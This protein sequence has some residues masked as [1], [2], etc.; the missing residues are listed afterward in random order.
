[1]KHLR[2]AAPIVAAISMLAVACANPKVDP[3]ATFTIEGKALTAA[4]QPLVSAEVR[5]VRYFHLNKLF[6]PSVD[7]LF[8]CT[9]DD[10]DVDGFDLELGLVKTLTTDMDGRFE[11][12][13]LGEDIIAKGGRR[14]SLGKSEVSNLVIIVLDPDDLDKDAGVFSYSQTFQQSDR[15]WGVGNLELWDSDARADVDMAATTGRIELS[16]NKIERPPSSPVSQRYRVEIRGQG[17]RLRLRCNE[18]VAGSSADETSFLGGCVSSGNRLKTQVSAHTVWTHYADNGRFT[19][20]VSGDG[21]DFRH[22][23]KMVV[24]AP[25]MDPGMN[26]D[27]VRIG[28]VWAVAGD[29][30]QD[31]ANSSATDGK[32]D[33]RV[34]IT[35]RATE[36]Y[37]KLPAGAVSDAGLLNS[38]VNDAHKACVTI[39]FQ[40]TDFNTLAEARGATQG[41]VQKGKFC[42]GGGADEEMSALVGFD[43]T[44]ANGEVAAWM[45]FT[46]VS[47]FTVMSA[48]PYFEAIGEVA[49]YEKK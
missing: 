43:T 46:A 2:A 39:E 41:W 25:L 10:C 33:T 42:G 37:V 40:G 17:R 38:L 6:V 13:V 30:E 45:R 24:S 14:D 47:D 3:S 35:N 19:A 5:L 48:S 31:L 7:Q 22:R 49:V 1:M 29:V 34:R 20:Y 18:D 28:G 16:W 11:L 15:L 12:A 9:A 27:P 32:I 23:Q 21:V 26:R 8:D 4:G 44:A 36:I